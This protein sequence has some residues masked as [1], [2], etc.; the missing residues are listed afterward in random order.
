MNSQ[1]RLNQWIAT[2]P[3]DCTITSSLAQHKT[4]GQWRVVMTASTGDQ[5]LSNDIFETKDGAFN[6]MVET[7]NELGIKAE[8]LH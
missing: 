1:L 2:L 7:L 5:I 8:R 4:T 6:Y 3:N